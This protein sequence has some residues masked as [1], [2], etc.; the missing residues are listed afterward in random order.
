MDR[1]TDRQTTYCGIT[2]L[3]VTLRGKHRL[4]EPGGRV[5]IAVM[6]YVRSAIY[7]QQLRFL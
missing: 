7:Q 5:V 4:L 2:A 3:C 6:I 1:Q